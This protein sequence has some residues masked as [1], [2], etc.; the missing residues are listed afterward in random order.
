MVRSWLT[1]ALLLSPLGYAC[2][3]KNLIID[4]DLFSDVEYVLLLHFCSAEI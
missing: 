3:Q 4:T 1:L 2:G